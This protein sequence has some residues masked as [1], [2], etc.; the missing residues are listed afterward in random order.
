MAGRRHRSAPRADA[1]RAVVVG[2]HHAHR[3]G[4]GLPVAGRHPVPVRRRRGGRVSERGAELLAV[5]PGARARH[6]QRR[7]VLRLAARRHDH[8]AD[9]ARCSF[10]G[11]AGAPASS[12]SALSAWSGRRRGTA[13]IAIAQRSTRTSIAESSPGS[14]QDATPDADSRRRNAGTPWRAT[15]REPEPLR[16]LRDVLHVRLRAVLLLHL[17]ADLPDPASSASRSLAG[18]FF[19]SLPFL[20]AGAANLAGGW[21]T[22]AL[23]RT[24]GLQHRTRARSGSPRSRPAPR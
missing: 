16:H 22:D 17:A 23:A 11:G 12:C 3:G 6:G 21:C 7:A 14:Q 5:V 9:R 13:R 19:A 15:A 4:A 1:H 8:R 2:V 20:L 10:S 18:G 24:R